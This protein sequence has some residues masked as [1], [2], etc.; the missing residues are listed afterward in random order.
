MCLIVCFMLYTGLVDLELP[1]ERYLCTDRLDVWNFLFSQ[2]ERLVNYLEHHRVLGLRN[3]ERWTRH[4]HYKAE[5][6]IQTCCPSQELN[7]SLVNKLRN[8]VK[9]KNQY[10]MPIRFNNLFTP[11]YLQLTVLLPCNFQWIK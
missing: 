4:T 3:V 10:I 7:K 9:I 6:V 1:R 5:E 2:W 11:V 8:L